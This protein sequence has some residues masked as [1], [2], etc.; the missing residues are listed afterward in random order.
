MEEQDS[1]PS[2]GT[3]KQGAALSSGWDRVLGSPYSG[4][5]NGELSVQRMS[6]QVA[7]IRPS[8]LSRAGG[9]LLWGFFCVNKFPPLTIV[10]YNRR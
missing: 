2:S 8:P 5:A 6:C 4:D 9:D 1:A 3:G 10:H 7:K